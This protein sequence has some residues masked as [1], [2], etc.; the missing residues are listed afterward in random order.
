MQQPPSED[1]D[2]MKMIAQAKIIAATP[3]GHWRCNRC[4]F[5]PNQAVGK[6]PQGP[7]L[8]QLEDGRP[9]PQNA[10]QTALPGEDE[11]TLSCPVCWTR[12]IRKNVGSLKW[13]PEKPDLKVVGEGE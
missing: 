2:L 8:M 5:K 10:A 9:F 6:T 12:F 7:A 11:L 1:R 3:K 13:K 4:G